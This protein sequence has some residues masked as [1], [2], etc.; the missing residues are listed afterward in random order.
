M[1]EAAPPAQYIPPGQYGQPAYNAAPVYQSPYQ[2]K[3]ARSGSTWKVLIACL[4]AAVAAAL[5]FGGVFAFLKLT[6]PSR[7]LSGARGL[8]EKEDYRGSIDA[9]DEIIRKWPDK[10]Q[11]AEAGTLRLDAYFKQGECLLEEGGMERLAEAEWVFDL[12]VEE[13]FADT[14]GL[15]GDRVRLYL[16]QALE[17]KN[18]ARFTE[19]VVYYDKAG[20]IRALTPEEQY[21]MAECLYLKGDQLCASYDYKEAAKAYERCYIL[22]G[23]GPLADPAWTNYVDMTV[24][25]ATREP[26]PP[27]ESTSGANAKVIVKNTGSCFKRLFF[28]GPTTTIVELQPGQST[29]V[30]IL[31]GYYNTFHDSP[32]GDVW[33]NHSTGEDFTMSSGSGWYELSLYEE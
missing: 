17:F 30:Y 7:K 4:C 26:P 33:S 28:S 11:A 18:A 24:A 19:A 29:T 27:K 1:Q 3:T 15:S 12:L 2:A 10:E 21:S 14:E 31:T 23:E 22:A 9:C 8:Y 6:E 5:V 13:E 16:A 25:G 32:G 20:G